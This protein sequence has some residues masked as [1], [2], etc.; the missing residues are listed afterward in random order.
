MSGL[1]HLQTTDNRANFRF[2]FDVQKLT[3]F[4]LGPLTPHQGLCPWTPLGAPPQTPL[5]GSRSALAMSS[6]HCLEEIAAT[7]QIFV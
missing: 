3:G 1:L 2:P 4:Q 7:D 5:I 6:L